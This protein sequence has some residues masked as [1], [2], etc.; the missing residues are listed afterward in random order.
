MKIRHSTEDVD[1]KTLLPV[2]PLRDVVVFPHMIYPLLIGRKFTINALQEAMIQDKQLL[3]LA[4]RSSTVDNPKATDL[5]NVGV[6]ARV[7]QV[8]KMPNGT[9][10]VLVEGL[11]RAEV[12]TIS[13]TNNYLA[14]KLIVVAPDES[15]SR[16]TEALSRSVSEQFAEYVRLNRRIPDE[17][18]VAV[19]SIEK[20][21]QLADSIAAQI[22]HKVEN[23][24][25][26]LEAFAVKDQFVLLSEMLHEE[27]EILKIEQKIDGTARESMSK[28]NRE[29]YLQHQLK[30]IKDELGQMDDAGAEVEDLL[31]R[32]QTGTY[33]EHARAKAE[34]EIKR[35]ARMH[36]FS[37]EA[38]VVRGY[39]EWLLAL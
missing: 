12:I 2:I 1:I 20:Y 16:E 38:G 8:M 6:V 10:K 18:L 30:A 23:K 37:A 29:A 32:L 17:V 9:F 28:S 25:R 19:A 34:E 7:L 36:T 22:L 31:T 3:L 14:A 4:Q 11:A 39:V 5:Y 27:I 24:Q 21:H 15:S 35:L 26:I 33:P 13:K